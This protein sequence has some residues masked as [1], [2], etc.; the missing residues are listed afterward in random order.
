MDDPPAVAR[1]APA[2]HIPSDTDGNRDPEPAPASADEAPV[3]IGSPEGWT[4]DLTGVDGPRF[5]DRTFER[6]VARVKRYRRP[7]TVALVELGGLDRFARRWG[8]DVA[9]EA[10]RTCARTLAGELRTS[11]LLARIETAR[12]AILLTETAEIPAINFIERARVACEHALRA[13][14]KDI[15]IS[16]GWANPPPGG[17]LADAAEQ[18]VARL[19][20]ELDRVGPGEKP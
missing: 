19:E 6:E 15:T 12:F 13:S 1:E 2:E 8:P 9:E 11:D 14:G 20:A 17:T 7:V 3:S 16:F 18:A 10:L 5:W 4:D